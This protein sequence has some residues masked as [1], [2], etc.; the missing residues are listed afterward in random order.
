MIRRSSSKKIESTLREFVN[1]CSPN[2]TVGTKGHKM[3][4]DYLKEKIS[5]F[6]PEN[7]G[8]LSVQEFVPQISL[9]KKMYRSDWAAYK[10][11]NQKM[12]GTVE[13]ERWKSFSFNMVKFLDRYKKFKAH[14]LIWEI[15]GSETPEEIFVIGTNFD[16]IV[17][18]KN[19]RVPLLNE[20]GQGADDN[21]SG[22][23]LAL[24][25]IEFFSK[26][27]PKKTLKVVFFDFQELGF[28]GSRHF[29]SNLSKELK[30]GKGKKFLGSIHLIM[31]GY[32]SKMRDQK[33]KLLN[34]EL[35]GQR[36]SAKSFEAENKLAIKLQD[37]GKKMGRSIDFSYKKSGF[38]IT[39]SVAFWEEHLPSVVFTQNW[40]DDP[41]TKRHHTSN[42]FAETLNFRTLRESF[43]YITGAVAGIL[44]D[45]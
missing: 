43:V 18:D 24:K 14:N 25:M 31:L 22:V 34:M 13:Y 32:D 1:C 5:S 21:G 30:A 27:R 44:N 6:D 28:L 19:L 38:G 7:E 33:K 11:S 17:V 35:H 41:N 40:A 10:K 9:A 29:V 39:D 36:P 3:A 26:N 12:A 2:R 16:N 20:K 23:S 42:D 45:L 4:I 8:V 15:K 37:Y